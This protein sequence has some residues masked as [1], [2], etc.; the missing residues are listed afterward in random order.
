MLEGPLAHLQGELFLLA[1]LGG[2]SGGGSELREPLG[3]SAA[4]EAEAR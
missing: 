2:G 3:V 1:Q 4:Y